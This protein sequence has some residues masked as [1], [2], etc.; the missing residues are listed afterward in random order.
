MRAL[1]SDAASDTVW[2]T[3]PAASPDITSTGTTLA[4][5]DGG[6]DATVVSGRCQPTAGGPYW[7]VEGQ[8]ATATVICA[9]GVTVPPGGFSIDALPAGALFDASTAT[10]TWTPTLS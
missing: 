10:L 1:S 6:P 8:T 4:G 2:A 7:I 3:G 9:T 5:L